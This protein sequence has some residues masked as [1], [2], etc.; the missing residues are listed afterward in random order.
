MTS[1]L[2]RRLSSSTRPRHGMP[3]GAALSGLA[4]CEAQNVVIRAGWGSQAGAK[5][6]TNASYAFWLCRVRVSRTICAAQLAAAVFELAGKLLLP[7]V[8]RDHRLLALQACLDERLL[9]P[10]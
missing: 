10:P 7:G 9:T 8:D 1:R 3:A 4:P 6:C 5:C 2:R